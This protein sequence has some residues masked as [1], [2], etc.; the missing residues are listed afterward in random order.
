[1]GETLT[2]LSNLL[3]AH[4][5]S[6]SVLALLIAFLFGVFVGLTPCVY[7]I[8]PLTVSYIGSISKGS[9][10]SGFFHSL[11]FVLGMAVVYASI[12]VVTALVGG[13]IGMIWNNGWV[14]LLL[15]NLFM[16]LALWQLGVIRI[17]LPQFVSGQGT[18]R[19]GVL[20]A[21]AVGA[22]SGLIVG[23]CTFPGLA[24]MMTLIGTGAQSGRAGSVFF[25]VAAMFLYSLGLGSLVVVCGTFSGLLANL[26]RSG[27]WLNVVEKAFAV[28]LIAA[29]ELFLIYL[30]QNAAFPDLSLILAGGT[31]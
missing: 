26:P 4:L 15:A 28:L 10:F 31:H 23:P 21:L 18:R 14:L 12:G 17:A 30:G 29:A 6:G 3:H 13:R 25:G 1:M 16:L 2:S 8:L 9:R 24:A 11:V 20:G 5:S 22:A 27:R 19:G 7:P